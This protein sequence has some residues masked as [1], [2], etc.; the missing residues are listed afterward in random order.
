MAGS[1]KIPE[2]ELQ[3]W[4]R[5]MTGVTPL[6]PRPPKPPAGDEPSVASGDGGPVPP[7]AGAA[8]RPAR[9]NRPTTQLPHLV[10]GVTAG[11]DHRTAERLR[12]GKLA[13][14][15]RLDL[16]GFRQAEA[17]A[18]LVGF[19]ERSHQ[20]G[21]RTLLVITGKGTQREDAGVLRSQVPRWLNEPRLR[22][23]V[24][25]FHPAQR[26]HGGDGAIYLLL[27]RA[28]G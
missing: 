15:A 22:Q 26:Q 28:R 25:G 6:D 17:H 3:L 7:K 14:E 16:H 9:P 24:I 13:I 1:R 21:L 11:L 27:R 2:D 12:R 4:R 5:A 8:H 10:P 20:A 18:E 23:R 19:V